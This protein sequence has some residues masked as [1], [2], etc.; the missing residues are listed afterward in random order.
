MG[1]TVNDGVVA[2]KVD[3][4]NIDQCQ[5]VVDTEEVDSASAEPQSLTA[6]E[7]AELLGVKRQ[8]VYAY[9]S[10]GLLHRRVAID[11]RT[12]LFNRAEVE[13]LRLG[14]RP[15]Q[16][17]EMRT[18]LATRLTRVADDGL[19]VRGRDVVELV[20]RGA[21]FIDLAELVWD[22]QV[23]ES[24]PSLDR[25]SPQPLP[26]A[27][28]RADP[29]ASL[30][31]LRVLVAWA[32]SCD[33]LR[34]DLDPRRVRAAGR[35]AIVAMVTGLAPSHDRPITASARRSPAAAL[36]HRLTAADP[37][38]ER[39]RALDA[40]LALLVEHGMATSTLAA[41]VAASVR[42]D[43]YSVIAAGLGVLGG[44]LHGRASSEVHELFLAAEAQGPSAAVAHLHRRGA[45]IPGLGHAV[46]RTQDPRYGA[47][48]NQVVSA[49]AGDPRLGI[50][51]GV[52]DLLAQRD[53][54]IPNVD[55]ALGA[56]TYLADMA[57]SA[58][59]VVFAVART[60]GW[61][62]HA[63]EEYGEKP[64][65]FRARANYVGPGP[66]VDGTAG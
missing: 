50:V 23:G 55:L 44:P 35:Q 54:A 17:G 33:P 65:R 34:H 9:V 40:A 5:R 58:G 26:A 4:V 12:S 16:D 21:G 64:L 18:I 25:T 8:T 45:R 28:G 32:S 49:W 27:L 14:R 56:L 63:L 42:A 46:Y 52:R 36:W 43:P 2:H 22:G 38:V 15:E 53:G 10:R 19:W 11:G 37:M 59:E 39:V 3:V 24:W 31:Q 47:L 61:L 60:V 41:R 66:V 13:E 30:E 20:D 62:G 51:F 6:R 48:L 29:L 7:V 57:S 1:S